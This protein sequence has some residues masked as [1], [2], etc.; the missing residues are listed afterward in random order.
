[1]L[2]IP[3]RADQSVTPI[4]HRSPERTGAEVSA[5]ARA[6]SARKPAAIQAT[7]SS[8]S[9]TPFRPGFGAPCGGRRNTATRSGRKKAARISQ[10]W[11]K[12]SGAKTP[13][14]RGK[15]W[16][17]WRSGVGPI[18][19]ACSSY[20]TRKASKVCMSSS[21]KLSQSCVLGSG[22]GSYQ[23][24]EKRSTR[25]MRK[26][27]PELLPMALRRSAAEGTSNLKGFRG[28]TPPDIIPHPSGCGRGAEQR[29]NCAGTVHFRARDPG[30]VL[31]PG[32]ALHPS[33]GRGRGDA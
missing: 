5:M 25:C 24:S 13:G 14:P 6:E 8:P 32:L 4:P 30:L 21:F 31:G 18:L 3:T 17:H 26:G 9:Y 12:S 23:T 20:A 11:A 10:R 27:T 16:M 28:V 2:K 19:P 1:M 7:T 22:T 33:G 29:C 15:M